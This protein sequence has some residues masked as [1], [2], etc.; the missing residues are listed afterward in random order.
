MNKTVKDLKEFL[1]DIPDDYE[2]S[3][4]ND[5]GIVFFK[6]T[7]NEAKQ[8]YVEDQRVFNWQP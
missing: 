4:T 5:D 6:E 2:V 3:L 8:E 1:R 7:W